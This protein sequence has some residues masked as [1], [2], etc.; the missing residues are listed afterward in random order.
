MTSLLAL[1]PMRMRRERPQR[2]SRSGWLRRCLQARP[3][4]QPCGNRRRQS[5][6]SGVG[7]PDRA[8]VSTHQTIEVRHADFALVAWRSGQSHHPA[9]DPVN[10]RNCPPGKFPTGN[11]EI[12]NGGR[13]GLWKRCAAVVARVSRC[14]SL[15]CWRCS[16]ASLKRIRRQHGDYSWTHGRKV[17][18]GAH[19]SK[20][21]THD[22]SDLN[23]P[24]EYPMAK[25]RKRAQ[26][27][28]QPAKSKPLIHTAER[29]V[30]NQSNKVL[31]AATKRY[32]KFA[33]QAAKATSSSNKKKYLAA[34]LTAVVLAGVVANDLRSRMKSPPKKSSAKR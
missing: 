23:D 32:K 29:A 14:Q 20:E 15:L 33:R 5:A 19:C 13:Y 7:V 4:G 25:R 6:K 16:H 26:R 9:D 27:T 1:K 30:L 24:Q 18:A 8:I 12:I 22:R 21:Y 11:L 34:A 17:D 3:G 10:L 2:S 28:S 31:V